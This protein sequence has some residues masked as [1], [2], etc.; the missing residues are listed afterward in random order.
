MGSKSEALLLQVSLYITIGHVPCCEHLSD[1]EEDM[2]NNFFLHLGVFEIQPELVLMTKTEP[3]MP[4]TLK[5]T[6]KI[7]G[8]LLGWMVSLKNGSSFFIT[9]SRSLTYDITFHATLV[10]TD[11]TTLKFEFNKILAFAQC[12]FTNS[13]GDIILSKN[14]YF[15]IVG[16]LILVSVVHQAVILFLDDL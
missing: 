2:L 11:V 4:I 5:C 15:D 6:K 1:K 8:E 16:K 12:Q 9:N 7:Q 14:I 10:N 3:S 13:S